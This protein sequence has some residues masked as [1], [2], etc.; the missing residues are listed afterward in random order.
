MRRA[1]LA[2]SLTR[3]RQSA[4]FVLAGLCDSGQADAVPAAAH[5]WVCLGVYIGW[6]PST[7]RKPFS[8]SAT[9][10]TYTCAQLSKVA[11]R[12]LLPLVEP[13]ISRTGAF[14]PNSSPTPKAVERGTRPHDVLTSCAQS[15]HGSRR[16]LLG[17][18]WG[19]RQGSAERL[20]EKPR[21]NGVHPSM[22]A[23]V[24]SGLQ[25]RTAQV[26]VDGQRSDKMLLKKHGFP[27]HRGPILRN[28]FCEDARNP[29]GRLHGNRLRRRVGWFQGVRTQCQPR[30]VMAEAQK[31]QAI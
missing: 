23:L 17:F 11:E 22:V 3:L 26:V 7:K 6:Y 8:R 13:H 31:C 9:S 29:R 30:L 1:R 16:L 27:G 25:Q 18:V 15:P 4:S 10:E 14:G 19:F 24:G 20:L 28:L 21:S 12:L 2:F 5:D